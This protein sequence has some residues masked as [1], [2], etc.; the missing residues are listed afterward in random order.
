VDASASSH[1]LICFSGDGK[2]RNM[3]E[4]EALKEVENSL[5]DFIARVLEQKYGDKWIDECG[6]SVDRIKRWKERKAVETKRQP[7]GAV[8]ER[9]LY[10]ADFYDLWPILK[11]NWSGEFSQALGNRRTIEVFLDELE[12]LRDPHAHQ[13]ELL[14]H[15]KHL[16]IGIS[17]EIRN[18]LVRYRSKMETGDDYYPR[19]ECVRDSLGNVWV[20]ADS[21]L[22]FDT[23]ARL[24]PGDTVEWVVSATDPMDDTLLY[25]AAIIGGRETGWQ[26]NNVLSLTMTNADVG[27]MCIVNIKIRSPREYHARG[28]Y[29]DDIDFM[30][31]V[32]PPKA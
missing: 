12:T 7:T 16:I 29:D 10:Y 5:R 2:N 9:L 18:R 6:V 30:Y 3:D 28:K 22:P 26:E 17:G 27:R 25:N 32:L 4:H 1:T 31:E 11:K 15:Q 14:P 23:G 13:R 21:K 24:R 8:E 20:P 19:L